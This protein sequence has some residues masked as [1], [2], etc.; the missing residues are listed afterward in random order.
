[1]ETQVP[2]KRLF[3]RKALQNGQMQMTKTPLGGVGVWPG[4]WAP[5]LPFGAS[6]QRACGRV[7][8]TELYTEVMSSKLKFFLMMGVCQVGIM[9]EEVLSP[10]Y[11]VWLP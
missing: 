9:K 7:L 11:P 6:C 4:S 8:R 5:P 10:S 3:P 2:G 1:M